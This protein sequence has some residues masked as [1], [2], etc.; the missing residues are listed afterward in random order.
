MF[1]FIVS[2]KSVDFKFRFWRVLQPSISH[3]W[4]CPCSDRRPSVV[5]CQITE[6]EDTYHK[7]HCGA[8][9]TWYDRGEQHTGGSQRVRMTQDT[10][11]LV[12][13]CR[14]VNL[15]WVHTF[16]MSMESFAMAPC[17]LSQGRWLGPMALEVIWCI[18]SVH[19]SGSPM[20]VVTGVQILAVPIHKWSGWNQPAH[21]LAWDLGLPF[22]T[23]GKGVT[24]W[25]F[26][27][28]WGNPFWF[29]WCPCPPN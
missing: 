19:I 1:N 2:T 18:S 13:R 8:R 14:I 17:M 20:I 28:G 6:L 4:V 21:I 16:D 7:C 12:L 5:V 29:L 15:I 24:H 22:G 23:W 25:P 26:G 3:P 11:I 9:N 27:V 10:L